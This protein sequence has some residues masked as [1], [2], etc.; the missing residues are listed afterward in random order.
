MRLRGY[1]VYAGR[2]TILC[3][4]EKLAQNIGG[5]DFWQRKVKTEIAIV[6]HGG[7]LDEAV[8]RVPAA[9][10][11]PVTDVFSGESAVFVAE[12]GNL[13][14]DGGWMREE[15]GGGETLWGGICGR[16][17]EQ[18]GGGGAEGE[19]R[20]AG[21]REGDDSGRVVAG[22]RGD[23]A[24]W[25]GMRRDGSVQDGN[26]PGLKPH[27]ATHQ[28]EMFPRTVPPGTGSGPIFE[29]RSG[30]PH[31]WSKASSHL[32]VSTFMR[33]MPLASAISMGATRPR[34]RD[35]RKDEMRE[36]RATRA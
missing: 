17:G 14:I 12:H 11:I 25:E 3:R 8:E 18:E 6:T 28:L 20:I 34:K 32:Q 29:R 30:P 9:V 35:G 22:E 21:C 26:V 36:M 2:V 16:D 31:A 13:G 15:V 23:D 7:T 27:R 24:V 19:Q 1:R 4:K 5:N 10:G 33:F